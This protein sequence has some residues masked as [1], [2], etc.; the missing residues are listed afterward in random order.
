MFWLKAKRTF[1]QTNVSSLAVK[2][3]IIVEVFPMLHD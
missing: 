1:E 2:I 3:I